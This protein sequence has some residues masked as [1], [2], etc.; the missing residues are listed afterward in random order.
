[1]PHIELQDGERVKPMAH[2][3]ELLAAIQDV[4]L[5]DAVTIA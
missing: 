1:L 2:G 4:Y 5:E 3:V